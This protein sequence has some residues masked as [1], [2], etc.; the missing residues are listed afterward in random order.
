MTDVVLVLT[1]V[2]VGERGEAHGARARRRAAG[3]VRQ[4]PAP[5]TS[6]YRWKGASSATTSGSWSSRP[7]GSRRRPFGA[8]GSELHPYELPEFLVLSGDDGSRRVSRRGYEA[9]TAADVTRPR[10][11]ATIEMPSHGYP[12]RSSSCTSTGISPSSPA[13]TARGSTALLFLIVFAETGL[14][15]TPF[16][17]GDS[18]LFA[19]GALAA[20]GALNPAI[21]AVVLLVAAVAGDAVNYAV[22]RSIGP[23]VFTA[24]TRPALLHRLLNRDHLKQGPC[25]LRAVRRQGGRARPVRADRPDVR[26]VR[27]RA[28]AR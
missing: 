15:V 21:V 23:R 10:Q 5:M 19:A 14:V 6:V 4:R 11:R 16:L 1:T 28:P 27:G 17:P 20:T 24:T 3:G 7:R 12:R 26:A 9:E 2:P 8:A 13:P 22:G 18:L 25:V